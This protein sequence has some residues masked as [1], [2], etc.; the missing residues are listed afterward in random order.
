MSRSNRLATKLAGVN[1]ESARTDEYKIQKKIKEVETDFFSQLEPYPPV[2]RLRKGGRGRNDINWSD[3]RE[4]YIKG[5]LVKLEDGTYVSEDIT[6]KELSD[7]YDCS[8]TTIKC[9]AAKEQWSRWRKLYLARLSPNTNHLPTEISTYV[10]ENY[11]AEANALNAITKLSVVANT[12]IEN[13][14]GDILDANEDITQEG[15]NVS[16]EQVDIFEIKE[17]VK[18]VNDIYTLQRKIYENRP[19]TDID[20]IEESINKKNKSTM[21]DRDRE[22]KIKQLEARIGKNL[23]I[24][25]G[26]ITTKEDVAT[27]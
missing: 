1:K 11:N 19:K 9:R 27:S 8:F 20:S 17:A 26:G 25:Q 16:I 3:I 14:F 5:K 6:H 22:A 15:T 23:S 24:I 21:S 10:Q 2:T 18:I 7:K 12:Y 4:E 13:K